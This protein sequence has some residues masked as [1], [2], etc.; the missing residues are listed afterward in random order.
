MM[1]INSRQ[2]SCGKVMFSVVSVCQSFCSQG[3]GPCTGLQTQPTLVQGHSIPLCPLDMFKLV[4][5][6]FHCAQ[7][8]WTCSDLFNLELSIRDLETCSNLFTMS[9]DF[10]LQNSKCTCCLGPSGVNTHRVFPWANEAGRS[11]PTLSLNVRRH[12]PSMQITSCASV[13]LIFQNHVCFIF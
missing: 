9:T 12:F 1:V 6:G 13:T 7:T 2:Q 5:L 4:Q 8:T 10:L 11:I 3:R